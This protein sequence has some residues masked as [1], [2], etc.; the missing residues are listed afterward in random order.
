[1]SHAVRR[2][3]AVRPADPPALAVVVAGVV[4]LALPET[5]PPRVDGRPPEHA[6][7]HAPVVGPVHA[8]RLA[9]GLGREDRQRLAL[10]A[11]EALHVGGEHGR[12]VRVEIDEVGPQGEELGEA[13][14]LLRIPPDM[15]GVI[16]N[17]ASVGSQTPDSN[18][19]NGS[20]TITNGVR[21]V[22]DVEVFKRASSDRVNAGETIA[23]TLTVVNHGPSFAKDIRLIDPLPQGG[24][25]KL[26]AHIVFSRFDAQR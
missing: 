9:P 7:A 8:D 5:E 14:H 6:P 16:A 11:L 18:P 22:A 26:N 2:R 19:A 10:E 17:T 1:M 23:Y 3:E 15:S 4:V 20:A 12:V 21:L 24:G 13:G 25:T